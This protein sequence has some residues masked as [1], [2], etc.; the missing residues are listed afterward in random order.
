MRVWQQDRVLTALIGSMVQSVSKLCGNIIT[1]VRVRCIDVDWQT[2]E[3]NGA[4]SKWLYWLFLSHIFLHSRTESITASAAGA[5][6]LMEVIWSDHRMRLSP[7]SGYPKPAAL[8]FSFQPVWGHLLVHGKRPIASV[9]YPGSDAAPIITI[10]SPPS[11]G[12]KV[13]E[14]GMSACR[15]PGFWPATGAKTQSYGLPSCSVGSMARNK[16]LFRSQVRF[17]CI[18]RSRTETNSLRSK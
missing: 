9:I 10:Q 11:H 13:Q 15:W 3:H 14:D 17:S 6:S 4:Y 1:P 8:C 7:M 2:H 18:P 5:G 12:T 16:H